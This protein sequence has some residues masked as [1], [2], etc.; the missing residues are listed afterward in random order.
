MTWVDPTTTLK[1][2]LDAIVITP[3]SLPSI[4]KQVRIGWV[5]KAARGAPGGEL[6]PQYTITQIVSPVSPH[7]AN[8][9]VSDVIANYQI[10]VWCQTYGTTENSAQLREKMLVGLRAAIRTYRKD[11][12]STIKHLTIISEIPKDEVIG[13]QEAILRRTMVLVKATCRR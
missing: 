1:T 7:N 9:S 6:T 2:I 11:P 4:D 13:D 3:N 12:T 8:D 10:D 5:D